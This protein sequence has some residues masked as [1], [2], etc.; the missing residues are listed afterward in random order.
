MNDMTEYTGGREEAS[1]V[2]V[3]AKAEIDQQISTAHAYPRSMTKVARNILGYVTMSEASAKECTYSLPRGGTPITGPSIRLAEIVFSQ[4]GNC[5]GGARVV[6]VDRRE[7]FVEAEGI[8]HDLE[9]NAA[10]TKRVRRRISD[11]NG[12]LLSDDMIIVTGNAACSIA[13]RN[14]VLAGVPKALWGEAYDAALS[15]IK[16]DVKTLPERRIAA[17]KVMAA[18][19][20]KPEQVY[21][22]L[23]IDGERDLGLDQLAVLIGYHSALKNEEITVEELLKA[24]EPEAKPRPAGAIAAPAPASKPKADPRTN[25]VAADDRA[26][27]RDEA[28]AK[29]DENQA[30]EE[31]RAKAAESVEDDMKAL[32]ERLDSA[33][34]DP[35]TGEVAEEDSGDAGPD[36]DSAWSGLFDMIV[37]ELIGADSV[38]EVLELYAEQIDQMKAAA[39]DL[40]TRLQEEIAAAQG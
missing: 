20:L 3:L 16:G 35:E 33:G 29:R 9:T 12:K 37:N 6:H 27:K 38:D 4:F 11:R 32:E 17:M 14:A 7:M 21:A 22:I 5:R 13:F 36:D 18:F 31:V 10:T 25:A 2:Q 24:A 1:L 19:G 8:F 26:K 39:P 15:T 30:M 40:H 28:K 34:H 23:G